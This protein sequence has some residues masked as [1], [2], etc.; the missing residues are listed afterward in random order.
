MSFGFVANLLKSSIHRASYV[1]RYSTRPVT[2][3]ENIA[4]HAYYVTMYAYL[5]YHELGAGM[6][7]A[8]L[9]ELMSKALLHDLDECVTG[10]FQRQFKYSH[11]QLAQI[12]HEAAHSQVPTILAGFQA[13]DSDAAFNT[14]I[15]AKDDSLEGRIVA[16]ADFLAVVTYLHREMTFGNHSILDIFDE[17]INYGQSL[18]ETIDN[19]ELLGIIDSAILIMASIR[20]RHDD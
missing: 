12:I 18:R 20:R 16:V 9:G 2:H 17:C 11:P 15:K 4:E 5:I 10:D 19:S 3:Q 8:D 6:S 1:T 13:G 14:W 7:D